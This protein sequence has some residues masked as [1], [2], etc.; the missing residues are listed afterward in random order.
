MTQVFLNAESVEKLTEDLFLQFLTRLPTD[1]EKMRFT[2][3]L[4]DGFDRRNVPGDE[5][6]PEPEK[7][8]FPYVSWSN[9]L[10]GKANSIK[11]EQ[12]SLAR[13]GEPPTRLLR[14]N[15]REQ[16]EDALWALL[17]SPE[18]IIVP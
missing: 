11:Q 9:H 8:R 13:R 15:W 10:D 12:E 4:S 5:W 17:N 3:L 18:M 7:K 6:G 14:A 16:A 1:E 2:E